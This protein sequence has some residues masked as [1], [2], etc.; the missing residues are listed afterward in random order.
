MTCRNCNSLI[1]ESSIYCN[2]C[3]EKAAFKRLTIKSFLLNFL[4]EFLSI[5]NKLVK[6]FKTLFTRPENVINSYVNGFRKKYIN[7][8]PYLGLTLT[9]IGLQFFI[10]KKFF[11]ELLNFSLAPKASNEVADFKSIMDLI[12]DYQGLITVISIPI[13]ALISRLIFLDSK[14]Y[15]TAEHFVIISYASAQLYLVSFFIVLISLP[16]GVNYNNLSTYLA[17]PM[18]FYMIFL[19]KRLYDFSVIS[20]FLR[21]LAYSLLSLISITI[22]GTVITII[23]FII[24]KI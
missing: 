9:L 14:K 19:Y 8:I 16:M 18:F 2:S 20:S 13:Y 17:I 10:L 6:T 21:A 23:Y 5:D 3:G 15:N 24:T 11:P 4:H 7:A 22:F 12:Y 1:S